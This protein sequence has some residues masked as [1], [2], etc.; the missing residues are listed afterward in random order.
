M[1]VMSIALLTVGRWMQSVATPSDTVKDNE[2]TRTHSWSYAEAGTS[3]MPPGRH[4]RKSC[5]SRAPVNRPWL[6]AAR[7]DLLPSFSCLSF[8]SAGG[9]GGCAGGFG[10]AAGAAPGGWPALGAGLPCA[11]YEGF[12]GAGARGGAPFAPRTPGALK[13][14]ARGV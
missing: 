10:G 13:A 6:G 12:T 3:I 2:L 1:M 8:S 14:A 4:S 11:P 5:A 9:F 7:Q